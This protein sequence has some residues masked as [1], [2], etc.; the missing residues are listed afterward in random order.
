MSVL[1]VIKSKKSEIDEAL[2]ALR[3]AFEE[4]LANPTDPELWDTVLTTQADI[5]LIYQELGEYMIN[6]VDDPIIKGYLSTSAEG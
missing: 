6:G 4:Y 3:E 5:S 1:D 2:Q